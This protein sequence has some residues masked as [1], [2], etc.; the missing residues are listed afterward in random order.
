MTK[1]QVNVKFLVWLLAGLIVLSLGVH[2]THNYQ[3][4]QQADGFLAQAAAAE[5][6][7]EFPQAASALK[8]YLVFSPNDIAAVI[9]Y[10]FSLE[11]SAKSVQDRMQVA[12]LLE[13]ALAREPARHLLPELLDPLLDQGPVVAVIGIHR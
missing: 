8:Q 3:V 1:R 2:L 5:S 9:R 10:A 11:K 4:R 6:R 13:H 12:M 7:G